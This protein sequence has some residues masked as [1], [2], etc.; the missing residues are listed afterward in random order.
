MEFMDIIH[1]RCSTR[2]YTDEQITPQELEDIVEAGRTAPI[3]GGDYSMSHMTVVQDPT[4]IAEIRQTCALKRKDGTLVDPT[5]GAPTLIFLS[6]TGPSDDQIEYCNVACAIQSMALA[7]TSKGLGGVYLW[8]FLRKMRQHP[9][10][11][12]KLAFL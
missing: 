10:V 9:E 11:L 4:L 2:A 8:G 6:A 12:A 5:Y 1:A 7:A 3:A